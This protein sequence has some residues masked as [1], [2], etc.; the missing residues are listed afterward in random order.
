MPTWEI[1]AGAFAALAVL[2]NYVRPVADWFIGWVVVTKRTDHA[3]GQSVIGYLSATRRRAKVQGEAYNTTWMYV[4]PLERRA[5]VA[6]QSLTGSRQTFWKKLVPIWYGAKSVSDCECNPSLTEHMSQFLFIRGTVDWERLL[7]DALGWFD[8]MSGGPTGRFN[9]VIHQ[10]RPTSK[11]SDM[12]VSTPSNG[13]RRH[14]RKD[15]LDWTDANGTRLIGWSKDDI[16]HEPPAPPAEQLSLTSELEELM[17]EITFWHTSK[18]WYQDHGVPWKRG[19]VFAGPPGTGK[20]SYARAIAEKLDIPIHVF[21]LASASNYSFRSSWESMTNDTPCVALIEDIDAVF[22]GREN[23][24]AGADS[25]G[26]TFD[27]LLNCIDGVERSDGI[28]LVLTTN[29]VDTIDEAL[30]KRPG[31]VDRVI[32]FG[33]LDDAGRLKLA[34]RILENPV[35]AKKVADGCRGSSAAELQERCFRIAIQKRFEVRDET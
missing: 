15:S 4:L 34:L 5:R 20:T 35:L 21:D 33:P 3:L 17:D 12:E 27:C 2:W 9:V 8:L 19:Y 6:Y 10:D 22:H 14:L 18:K 13:R 7:V 32:E 24:A 16:R 29:C 26:L 25:T 30:I 31:R 28:L 23:V 1:I 11:S